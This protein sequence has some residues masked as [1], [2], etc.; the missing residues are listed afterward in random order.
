MFAC[1]IP[2]ILSQIPPWELTCPTCELQHI[3]LVRGAT[4]AITYHWRFTEIT[5]A[6][7]GCTVVYT[8]RSFV[9]QSTGSAFIYD[10]Q[11]FSYHLHNLTVYSLLNCLLCAKLFCS[12]GINLSS[13]TSFAQTP[14]VPSRVWIAIHPTISAVLPSERGKYVVFCWV[15]GH[16]GLS[17]FEG[18]NAAA[19]VEALFLIELRALMF[20][21]F[22]I[23]LLCHHGGTNGPVPGATNCSW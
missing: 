20:T 8:N 10:Y 13:I 4:F 16:T 7:V 14:W 21:S 12:S 1:H 6:Y 9:Q 3:R 18:T 23:V 11:I 2:C 19:K 15:R 5:F 22:F 17:G